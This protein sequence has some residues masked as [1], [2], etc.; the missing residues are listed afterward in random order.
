[1]TAPAAT[2]YLEALRRLDGLS[3]FGGVR[4][5]LERMERALARLGDPQRAYPSVH[6]AGTN[7]KGSTAAMI[8][9]GL[10][11]CGV[12]TGLY[13][14]PHLSRF[15]ERVQVAGREIDRSEVARLVERVIAVEPE[16]TFF[17]VVTA[18]ALVHF[19]EQGVELA[20]VET[21]LGGRL[22]ATNVLTP[23]VCVLTRIARD[24][25]ELLGEQLT[26]IAAEKAGIIKAGVPVVCAPAA[27]PEVLE[28]LRRRC[29]EQAAPLHLAGRDFEVQGSGAPSRGSFDYRGARWR[30]TGL[31]LPLPGQHQLENAGLALAAL[32]LLDGA[33]GLGLEHA[34]LRRGLGQ[35]RW[36]GR[37]ERIGAVLLD[38]AHNPAGCQTLAA[39]LPSVVAAG[40]AIDLVMGVLGGAKDLE[41]MLEPLL[42]RCRGRLCFTR[43]RSPRATD[44]A[45]LARLAPRS[46]IHS[47]LAAA[48]AALGPASSGR[49]RLITGSLYLVGEARELLLGEPTDPWCTADPLPPADRA[50]PLNPASIR[51]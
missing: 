44:P 17:E 35:V 5:G 1:M 13:T 18:A 10:Q 22:D 3:R 14:S 12:R 28:L 48:L 31:G 32:E 16:L 37:L 49:T 36:P 43:P 42:P 19:A 11:A 23:R 33:L 39:A 6:I 26:Q 24:H 34:Q 21:G 15:T 30:M 2:A 9:A 27:D 41:A 20:V 38:G 50:G 4:L 25:T 47:D 46:E 7:G 51:L 45:A 29:E 40:E 8:A